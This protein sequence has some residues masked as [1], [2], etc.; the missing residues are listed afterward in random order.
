MPQLI[1]ASQSPRRKHILELLGYSFEIQP[2]SFD[3]RSISEH[4]SPT[5]YVAHVS[6]GKAES[7]Q[8][9]PSAVILAS[10]LTVWSDGRLMHKPATREEARATLPLIW[11][12]WHDEV[13]AC[14][15]GSTSLGWK[16]RVDVA[17]LWLSEL[18]PEQ[19]EKYLKISDPTDKAGGIDIRCFVQVAGK[20]SIKIHGEATTIIGLN[21]FAAS[22]LLE[23][24]GLPSPVS[25]QKVE[26]D[27]LQDIMT[28]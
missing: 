3:E 24:F 21:A 17:K 20:N 1:L 15:A 22:T 27:I 11:N 19:L 14:V 28:A 10:D 2:S 18:T 9:D 8:A 4:H 16:T 23:K 7:I 25:P 5:E 13:N 12:N 26:N 6:L